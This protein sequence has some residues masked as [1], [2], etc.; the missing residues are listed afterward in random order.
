M[1][2][3]T[4]PTQDRPTEAPSGDARL[5]VMAPDAAR[6]LAMS[7]RNLWDLTKREAI[8]SVRIGRSVRYRLSDLELWVEAGCPTEPGAAA[9]IRKVGRR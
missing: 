4:A 6:M 9:R 8:P 3:R 7:P 1:S 2:D 5:L